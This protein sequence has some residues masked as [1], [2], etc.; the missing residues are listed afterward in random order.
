MRSA[1]RGITL[2]E[3]TLVIVL[4][5]LLAGMAIPALSSYVERARN[6]RAVGEIGR[7]SIELYRW[8]SNH[9]GMFPATL[10]GANIDMP[11]DPWGNA[12]AYANVATTPQNDLRKDKNLNPI[13]SDFDL[14][15]NGRDG[16]TQRNLTGAKARDDVVRANNGAFIGVA[17]DY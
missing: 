17:R 1:Q 13:N 16:E 6:N 9:G 14:Y 2:L 12:Y 11:A 15:S 10:A 3:L 8:R 4:I 5:G 7:V